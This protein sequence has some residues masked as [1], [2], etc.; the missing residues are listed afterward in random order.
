MRSS[1]PTYTHR[2]MAMTTSRFTGSRE[3]RA[4]APK[5]TASSSRVM[6][7]VYSRDRGRFFGNT[8]LGNSLLVGVS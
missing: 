7:T 6:P 4:A 3:T 2:K 8:R 1:S 5:A